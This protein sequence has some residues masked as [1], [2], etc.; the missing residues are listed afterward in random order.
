ML[1]QKKFS[2]AEE[3]IAETKS[4]YELNGKYRIILNNYNNYF[5]ALSGL[6]RA[7]D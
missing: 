6:N 5:D 3:N 2:I 4:F 7:L 1:G